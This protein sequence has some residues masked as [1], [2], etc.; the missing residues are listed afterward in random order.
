MDEDDTRELED[1]LV[2]EASKTAHV[3]ESNA[4][5][6]ANKAEDQKN[7]PQFADSK[8][9]ESELTLDSDNS[10][11]TED[12]I[13]TNKAV[14]E[15]VK[16]QYAVVDGKFYAKNA[17]RKDKP[18]FIDK[19]NKLQAR[20]TNPST[21]K[22]LV[23]IAQARDWN[24][25]KVRGQND[26]KREVWLEA[27]A[28]G[29]EVKGYSPKEADLA[30]LAVRSKDLLTNEVSKDERQNEDERE[31]D[32]KSLGVSDKE[33]SITEKVASEIRSNPSM[34]EVATKNPEFINDA[35]IVK[36]ADK[37]GER[38]KPKDKARF[39]ETVKNQVATNLEAGQ[40]AQ[41]INVRE[42]QQV[43]N[44]EQQSER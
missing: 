29:L 25:I 36:A 34:V 16:N 20:N 9:T 5:D 13:K 22:A 43:K 26:F 44:Q 19:G 42:Q 14:P 3:I 28:R 4:T 24:S 39:V 27:S 17:E 41:Q 23:E 8:N 32:V 1:T 35:A 21:A 37:Y 38:M 10:I 33:K 7:K 31:V 6:K 30:L 2:R 11:E 18:I 15:R 12:V 40:P